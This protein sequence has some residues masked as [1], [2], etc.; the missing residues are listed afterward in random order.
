MAVVMAPVMGVAFLPSL[1]L[2]AAALSRAGLAR[3]L[4]LH[5][6][7]TCPQVPIGALCLPTAPAKIPPGALNEPVRLLDLEH[8]GVWGE[9]L[10]APVVSEIGSSR[11][12]LLGHDLVTTRLRPYLGKTV[13]LPE[14]QIVGTPEWI[15]LSLDLEI[16]RPRFLQLML[17]G[18]AYRS[19]SKRLSSGQ[20]HPRIS[21]DIL[22]RIEVPLPSLEAQDACLARADAIRAK[23]PKAPT[24][25]ELRREVDRVF[26]DAFQLDPLVLRAE[27]TPRL[28]WTSLADVAMGR[29]VRFSWRYH[30]PE[31]RQ[32]RKDLETLSSGPLLGFLRSL[33]QLG[34]SVKP[35]EDFAVS[36]GLHYLTMAGLREWRV[37]PEPC[38]EISETYAEANPGSRLEAG[39]VLMARSGE[40]TIGKV[41][42]VEDGLEGCFADFVIRIQADAS[43]LDP[44]FLRYALMTTHYQT[45]IV[46][47]KKGLGNNTN[48]FPIQLHEF[49]TLAPDLKKQ[50][51]VI[52]ELEAIEEKMQQARVMA[53]ALSREV[54][55]MI[56]KTV[57]F[58]D[59]T[60]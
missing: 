4:A 48:I 37:N 13:L 3:P 44:R 49:P 24:S 35:E 52:A 53:S 60:A 34:Q 2:S 43:R 6:S 58:E 59:K 21:P 31:S 28:S 45:L 36:T 55:A 25:R 10:E 54:E 16:V 20:Q 39:D 26:Q 46:A 22:L 29:D 14:G 1:P 9:I 40:G 17:L 41:G 38:P 11:L 19:L 32:A 15:P 8:C 5:Q 23:V 51:E 7:A 57:L 56:R 33:S 27:P 47:E 50:G 30:A 42:L 18:D 12:Q